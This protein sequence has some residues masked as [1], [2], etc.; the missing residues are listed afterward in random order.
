M[1]PSQLPEP[2]QGARKIR[3]AS[4]P[5]RIAKGFKTVS[6]YEARTRWPNRHEITGSFACC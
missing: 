2:S 3:E 5:Y 6:S 1:G 4:T